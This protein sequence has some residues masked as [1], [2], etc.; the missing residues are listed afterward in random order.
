[1]WN[2]GFKSYDEMKMFWMESFDYYKKDG[3]TWVLFM[4]IDDMLQSIYFRD[5]GINHF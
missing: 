3:E 2:H 5:F 4:R 1:M